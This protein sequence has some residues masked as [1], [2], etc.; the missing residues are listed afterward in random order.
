[1]TPE[2]LQKL[3]DAGFPRKVGYGVMNEHGNNPPPSLSELI[4]ACGEGRFLL[5]KGFETAPSGLDVT[6]HWIAQR[7][8]FKEVGSTPEEAVGMLYLV[9]KK[10]V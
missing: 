7:G 5:E 2:L 10:Q 4:A 6:E 8:M 3:V 1:M 9:L